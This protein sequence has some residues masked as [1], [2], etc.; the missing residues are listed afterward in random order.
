MANYTDQDTIEAYLKRSLTASE[1]TF[2]DVLLPAV[3]QAIDD[4]LGTNFQNVT[5]DSTKYFDGLGEKEINIEPVKE[6]TSVA[7]V[8]SSEDVTY[9]YTSDEYVLEP[10][11]KTIKTSIR[12][13][14]GSF[15]D[16]V[17][18]IKVVAKFT[19]NSGST[20]PANVQVAAT[21]MASQELVTGT[22]FESESIEGYSYK[23]RTDIDSEED[24]KR[25]L[26]Q[27]REVIL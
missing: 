20:I 25:L 1:I 7:N 19:S 17:K 24:L 9:T 22:D 23:V 14:V 3:T 12:K 5:V 10:R 4:W 8:D 27:Y 18:N 6:L 21:K 16:G 11:N 2:L 15:P 13:R 26:N